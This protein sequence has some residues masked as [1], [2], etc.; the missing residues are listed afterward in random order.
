M[1]GVSFVD[2]RLLKRLGLYRV[3]AFDNELTVL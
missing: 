1:Q 3:E 2:P